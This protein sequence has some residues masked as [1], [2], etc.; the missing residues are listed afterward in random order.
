VDRKTGVA[1]GD[2]GTPEP[3]VVLDP[4]LS[5]S[6][7]PVDGGRNLRIYG[8]QRFEGLQFGGVWAKA[9]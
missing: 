7:G 3:G 5:R 2:G 1:G 8:E 6:F 9:S 4:D